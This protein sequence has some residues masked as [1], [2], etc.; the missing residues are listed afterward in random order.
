MVSPAR[1]SVISRLLERLNLR[2]PTLFLL[3]GILTLLDFLV[4]DL[5]PFV[6]EIM[7][8]LTTALFGTWKKKKGEGVREP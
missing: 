3:F 6:D 4:P 1:A 7:L 8:A 5:I 2:F